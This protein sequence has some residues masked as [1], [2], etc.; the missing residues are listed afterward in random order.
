MYANRQNLTDKNTGLSFVYVSIYIYTY[1]D[2]YTYIWK[3]MNVERRMYAL[4]YTI[5]YKGLEDL[6]ILVS[7]GV[8]PGTNPLQLLKEYSR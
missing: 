2:I 1:M 6:Q 7:G 4:F 8:G 3:N 5:L